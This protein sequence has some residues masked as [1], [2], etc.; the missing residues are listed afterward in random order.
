MLKE[1]AQWRIRLGE[2]ST[3]AP[4]N[5]PLEVL[6]VT[7]QLLRH[8]RPQRNDPEY[9]R[10]GLPVTT[11]WMESLVKE[12]RGRVQGTEMFWNISEAA[13]AILPIRAASISEDDRLKRHLPSRPGSLFTRRPK[14]PKTSAEKINRRHAPRG[15]PNR[16]RPASASNR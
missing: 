8:N 1:P 11:A 6:R 10:P 5:D 16:R 12:V 15:S 13:E 9:G 2:R 3:E 7:S 14:P 4:G